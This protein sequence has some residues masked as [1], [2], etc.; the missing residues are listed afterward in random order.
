MDYAD[1]PGHRGGATTNGF[2][3]YVRR[4]GVRVATGE[5]LVTEVAMAE[6]TAVAAC[7]RVVERL[8]V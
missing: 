4:A 6:N 1:L 7:D 2:R 8:G 5:P 3:T